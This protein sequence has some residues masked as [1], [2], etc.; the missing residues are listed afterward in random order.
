[1]NARLT[2]LYSRPGGQAQALH[3]DDN[4]NDGTRDYVMSCIVALQEKTTLEFTNT[5][6]SE[7][8]NTIR[9]APGTYIYF[10]GSQIHAGSFY[11]DP[12]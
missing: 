9:F 11:D 12:T 4:A 5:L 1:M 6:F 7:T 2:V 10:C 3:R 8:R